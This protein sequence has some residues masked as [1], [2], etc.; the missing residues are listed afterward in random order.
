MPTSLIVNRIPK[1]VNM[2]T[3]HTKLQDST[4]QVCP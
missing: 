1:R 3:R 4:S 2:G